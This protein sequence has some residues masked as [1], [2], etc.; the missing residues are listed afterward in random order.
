MNNFPE[1]ENTIE[2]VE[3]SS[4]IF[5]APTEHKKSASEFK[6]KRLYPKIIAA[7]LAVAI[8]AG[9]TFA[10]FKLVKVKETEETTT[11]QPF[12]ILTLDSNN[13]KNITVYNNSGIFKLYSSTAKAPTAVSSS[14]AAPTWFIEGYTEDLLSSTSIGNLASEMATVTATREVTKRTAEECG[15]STPKVKAEIT[16]INGNLTTYIFGN[17]SPDKSGYYFKFLDS[18]KIYVVSTEFKETVD[19]TPVSLANSDIIPGITLSDISSKYKTDSGT[20]ASFDTLTLTGSKISAPLI[21]KHLNEEAAAGFETYK[22]VSPT[23]RIASDNFDSVVSMFNTGISVSGAYALDVKPETLKSLGFN[24]PDFEAKMEVDGKVHY[25]KF[26]LQADGNFAAI[27]NDSVI[28]KMVSPDSVPFASMQTSEFYSDWLTINFLDKLKEF[29]FTAGDKSY[30]FKFKENPEEDAEDAFIVSLNGK[31]M[32]SMP[33]QTFYEECIS[34]KCSDYTVNN[35]KGDV[36]YSLTY[37]YIDTNETPE[38]I[39]FRKFSETK[40]EYSINGYALGKV[41]ATSLRMLENSIA[42]ILEDIK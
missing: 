29:N 42:K 3:E 26:K 32:K 33:F 22:F 7:F 2:E 25:Y 17:E 14:D 34:L 36:Q 31:Y 37:T 18:D 41:N 4:T 1:N 8:L 40:Y 21:A 11:Y 30:T 28:V 20:L 39:E 10:I 5:S 12:D 35:I 13:F 38:I 24:E 19:F 6:K 16:D 27:S 9:S 23:I 15:L